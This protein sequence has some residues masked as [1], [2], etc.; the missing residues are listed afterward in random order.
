MQT[1][2]PSVRVDQAT[3]TGNVRTNNED[4]FG[5]FSVPAGEL[6]L[7]ADGIGGNAGGEVASKC[8]IKAF[9][10]AMQK[11]VDTPPKALSQALL[12]AD[13]C[14]RKL[15]ESTAGLRGCGTTLVAL[16]LTPTGAWHIHAGDSRVYKFSQGKL[17]QLG[18]DHSSVQDMLSA[19][20]I[21]E[22]QA[23]TA[24]KNVITQ[25]LGGNVNANYCKPEPV[26]YCK[27]DKFLLCTDGLWGMVEDET[28]EALLTNTSKG[29]EN[30]DSLLQAA[31]EAGGK[32]NV[33]L[34]V[35][36]CLSGEEAPLDIPMM[37]A[38]KPSPLSRFFRIAG[39]LLLG[40]VIGGG[41][42]FAYP[43]IFS[44]PNSETSS[45]GQSAGNTAPKGKEEGATNAPAE[46]TP[47]PK[48]TAASRQPQSSVPS[49]GARGQGVSPEAQGATSPAATGTS[50]LGAGKGPDDPNTSPEARKNAGN[51]P[52]GQT[53]PSSENTAHA[54][55]TQSSLS[56]TGT[57]APSVAQ[58]PV[59]QPSSAKA[60][61]KTAIPWWSWVCLILI[62]LFLVVGSTAFFRARA[63]H[64][65]LSLRQNR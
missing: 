60:Q 18:R 34:Q 26:T 65:R 59:D 52:A 40:C 16:L 33:T 21:T 29:Q 27:G 46:Q 51:S 1:I 17:R 63:R 54:P 49:A 61:G 36:E 22:A 11:T 13:S 62:L 55:Q 57:T 58:E 31:L 56:S 39:V 20:L 4:A 19:G 64:R 42:V 25:S 53:T 47:S 41:A 10:D 50:V 35:V 32:D 48:N 24:P 2:R 38:E 15:G 37:N 44:S 5:W 30:V 43:Y 3:H 7:V 6:I 12:Y 45:A 8:A 23:K 28:M 14:V 9:S